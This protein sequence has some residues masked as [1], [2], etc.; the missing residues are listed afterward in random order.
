MILDDL[1]DFNKSPVL[2]FLKDKRV[3]ASLFALGALAPTDADAFTHIYGG[4]AYEITSKMTV[5]EIQPLYHFKAGGD[6]MY[7]GF[8][9]TIGVEDSQ[10]QQSY[11]CDF[12]H[13]ICD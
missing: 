1:L 10:A 3:A 12:T 6:G 7:D 5:P 8:A 4:D 2:N 11:R 9:D 13:D